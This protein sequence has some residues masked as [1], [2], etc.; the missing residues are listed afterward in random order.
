MLQQKPLLRGRIHQLAFY[1]TIILTLFY[2]TIS[3]IKSYKYELTLYIIGQLT[4]FGISSKYHLTDWKNEKTKKIFQKLDHISIFLLISCTQ[5]SF[6]LTLLPKIEI[7]NKI[8]IL[9]WTITLLGILK[10]ICISN[11]Y[12]IIDVSLYMIHG[13][14]I[15]PFFHILLKYINIS[16]M[17]Y[18]VFG[19]V[20]YIMGGVVFGMHRP[21]P[22][23]SVFGYHEVF[24]VLTVIAN[25][26]FMIPLLQ[27]Y[28][29]VI[30]GVL[31]GVSV[32]LGVDNCSNS[33]MGVSNMDR[34]LTPC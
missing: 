3:L 23:P 18:L 7:V 26:C 8:L 24:H 15:V 19:G 34:Y 4:L 27:W 22:F 13:V 5:S 9:T 33:S 32:S 29:G 10:I 31:G 11:E 2:I 1:I 6:V 16:K 21:D 14:S 20:F 30:N 25:T 28:Y 17:F 12:E